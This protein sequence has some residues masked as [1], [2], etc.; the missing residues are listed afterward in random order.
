[1][2]NLELLEVSALL[3]DEMDEEFEIIEPTITMED[4]K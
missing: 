3:A 2:S 4:L 1:M